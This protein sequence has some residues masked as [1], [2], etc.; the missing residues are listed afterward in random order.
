MNIPTI[1]APNV[2][3]PTINPSAPINIELPQ[4]NT[5]SKVVVIAKPN[6][7]PFTGY[8]FDGTWSHIDETKNKAVYSGIDPDS[9]K[10]NLNNTNPTPAAMVGA[11]NGRENFKVHL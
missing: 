9:L 4:P 10:G 5:P 6:A 11:Y 8:Y 2:P 7:E 3:V 1:S